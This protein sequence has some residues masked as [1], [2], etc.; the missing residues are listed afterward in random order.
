[1]KGDIMGKTS[2]LNSNDPNN[3]T[4]RIDMRTIIQVHREDDLFVATDLVTNVADQ[5]RTEEEAIANLKKGLEG[6]YKA[7]M[8]LSPKDRKTAYLDIE[9]EKYV[10]TSRPIS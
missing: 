4:R 3:S 2:D 5:G 7:L 10:E 8:E 6:H 1:M 9:V